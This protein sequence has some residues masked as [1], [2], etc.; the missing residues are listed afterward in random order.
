MIN[1][2][3]ILEQEG[4]KTDTKISTGNKN[5]HIGQPGHLKNATPSVATAATDSARNDDDAPSSCW[6]GGGGFEACSVF[7]VSGRGSGAGD[8][9]NHSPARPNPESLDE[10]LPPAA[11]QFQKLKTFAA[12]NYFGTVKRDVD[13]F[14]DSPPGGDN[15]TGA[16]DEEFDFYGNLVESRGQD[17]ELVMLRRLPSRWHWSN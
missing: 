12:A 2:N 16:V 14:D 1:H 4:S 13:K 8:Y 3:S 9:L 6:S 10:Q 5:C 17:C 11:F 7:S 15:T